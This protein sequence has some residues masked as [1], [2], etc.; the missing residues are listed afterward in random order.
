MK[1][2]MKMHKSALT[3]VQHGH[4]TTTTTATAT[5]AITTVAVITE[6]QNFDCLPHSICQRAADKWR[7]RLLMPRMKNLHATVYACVTL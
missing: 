6:M 5:A 2:K 4:I 1:L 7:A 3:Q